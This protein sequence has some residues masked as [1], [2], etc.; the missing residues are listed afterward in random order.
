MKCPEC[1]GDT[2]YHRK[3]WK[4]VVGALLVFLS[5]L[6]FMPTFAF[7]LV[8][9]VYGVYLIA[10]RRECVACGWRE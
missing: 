2:E 6:L 8:L 5:V 10:G 7:S 9:A 3:I 1:G 4:I